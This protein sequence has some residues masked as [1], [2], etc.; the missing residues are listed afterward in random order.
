MISSRLKIWP[1]SIYLRRITLS[2]W[3]KPGKSTREAAGGKT[4]QQTLGDVLPLMGQSHLGDTFECLEM[5]ADP[6]P[7]SSVTF[8]QSLPI[9]GTGL[10]KIGHLIQPKGGTEE[11]R[12]MLTLVS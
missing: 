4:S 9:T 6:S 12:N 11:P 1:L 10:Q 2:L 5:A 7:T 8:K 3:A